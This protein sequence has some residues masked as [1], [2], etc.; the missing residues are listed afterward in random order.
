MNTLVV[1]RGSRRSIIVHHSNHLIRRN[2]LHLQRY[3]KRDGRRRHH[4]NFHSHVTTNQSRRSSML[5]QNN[6]HPPALRVICQSFYFWWFLVLTS[7]LSFSPVI[8]FSYEGIS[9]IVWPSQ[10]Y[11]CGHGRHVIWGILFTCARSFFIGW[12]S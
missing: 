9:S 3:H 5:I 6:L 4:I 11:A 8:P 1:R 10:W 2:Y 12:S 7:L